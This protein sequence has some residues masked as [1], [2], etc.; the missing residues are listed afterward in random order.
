MK[1]EK[2]KIVD[3]EGHRYGN[4]VNYYNFHPA[5]ERIQQ[6]PKNIWNSTD[7]KF[8]A[9]DIGCNTGN[10]SFSLYNFLQCNVSSSSEEKCKI[11]LLGVDLD[12]TLIE[13]AQLQYSTTSEIRFECLDFLSKDREHLITNY[14]ES[15][16]KSRFNVA[17]CFSITMWIHLNHGDEGLIKFLKTVCEL[18][19]MI[20]IEPQQW[21]SYRNASRRLRRANVDDFLLLNKLKFT[22]DMY[23][24]IANILKNECNFSNVTVTETNNWQRRVLIYKRK[25]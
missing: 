20:V 21:K 8:S 13:R 1:E 24:H 19:D 5:E 2:E 18:S 3:P 15:V 7:C 14:L 25:S 4:F 10:L 17:F 11:S 16:Q 6:L 22:G 9:L 23:L 12:P